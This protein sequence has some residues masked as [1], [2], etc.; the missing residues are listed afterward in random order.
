MLCSWRPRAAVP[1]N[2]LQGNQWAICFPKTQCQRS[3]GLERGKG[4][5][6]RAL[7][8]TS[9]TCMALHSLQHGCGFES[10]FEHPLIPP[11]TF[12]NLCK[13]LQNLQ[14]QR[15]ARQSKASLTP[16]PGCRGD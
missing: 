6:C 7:T 14:V 5:G 8:L 9:S 1:D 2:S 13:G 12:L 10:T 15:G 11:A 16:L 4:A 3:R